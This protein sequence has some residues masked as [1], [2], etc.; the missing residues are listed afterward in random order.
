MMNTRRFL[1]AMISMPVSAVAFAQPAPPPPPL[2]IEHV[3][4]LPMTAGGTALYDQTVTLQNGRIARIESSV[5][6]TVGVGVRRVDGTGKYLMPSLTDA[7]VHLESDRL[8]RLYLEDPNIPTGTVHA[9]D[10]FLPFVANGVLQV[11]DLS[12][13]PETVGQRDEVESGRM[14]G[15]HI[16]LAA[17]IDGVDP[18]CPVGMTRVAATPSDGRQAVRDA[19]AEGYEMIKVYSQLDLPTFTAIVDEARKLKMPVVG[20]IPQ[21][22]KG[23]TE[24]F[25]QPGY[26]MV[27][28]AEEFA[29]QTDPPAEQDIPRYVEMAKRNGTWLTGTLSLDERIL[30][31]ALHPETLKTRPELRFLTPLLY[32]WDTQHNPYVKNANPEFVK[33]VRSI[34]AFNKELIPAFAAA[35]IPV[36]AGTDTLVPGLVAG[37]ALHDELEAMARYGLSN[38]QVL[39]GTTRLPAEWLGVAGD[40]GVIAVG[41]RADL[42]LL[43]ADPMADVA[44]TRKI[45]AVVVGGRFLSRAEL[46]TAMEALA[47]R[48]AKI[49]AGAAAI[50]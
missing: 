2:A 33:T 7:H 22:G 26:G 23:L 48:Y 3:E 20:H 14:V 19:A 28:H 38:K 5:G 49:R 36:L 4:V 41:K 6:A 43:D 9:E 16:A 15:P 31:Q 35:G 12:A 27:A 40:R 17:M 11:I 50:H 37:F 30:E 21:R 34:I 42:L 1:F 24:K 47:T 10:L 18:L 25:F 45:A 44:N 39:E 8:L 32:V 13:T 46:D 29:Q